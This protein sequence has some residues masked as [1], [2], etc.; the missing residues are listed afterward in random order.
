MLASAIGETGMV[1][2]N[3]I[4]EDAAQLWPIKPV[5]LS[6]ARRRMIR[7]FERPVALDIRLKHCR[8]FANIMQSPCHIPQGIRP[9]ATSESRSHF[10]YQRQMIGKRLPFFLRFKIKGMCEYSMD[11]DPSSTDVSL[12]I[13]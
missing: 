13:Q 8:H 3:A 12:M 1:T 6:R 5:N 10:P 4:S 7:P 9:K 2:S 11:N